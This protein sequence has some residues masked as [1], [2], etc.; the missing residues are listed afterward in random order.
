M[1]SQPRAVSKRKRDEEGGDE[2]KK[3]KA[4]ENDN[5]LLD[6]TLEIRLALKPPYRGLDM[7][8]G[9]PARRYRIKNT[10]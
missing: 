10:T 8:G 7:R 5:G 6:R 9:G 4:F 1:W 3:R 2:S